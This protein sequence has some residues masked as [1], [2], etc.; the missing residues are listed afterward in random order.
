MSRLVK[1]IPKNSREVVHVSVDHYRGHDLLNLRVWYE[2]DDGTMRPG[3]Q[4]LALRLALVPELLE[5]LQTV[6][7]ESQGQAEPAPKNPAG[8]RW[9]Q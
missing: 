1:R 8:R 5:A 6:V 3:R 2:S 9:R 4:G 7:A